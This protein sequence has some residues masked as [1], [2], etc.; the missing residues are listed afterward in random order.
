M[1]ALFDVGIP[2]IDGLRYQGEF[3]SREEELAL[4][5]AIRKLE[6]GAV[7]FRGVEARRRVVQFG[8]DYEFGSRKATPAEPVP[9]FLLALRKQ[10]GELIGLDPAR[11]EEV[12]VTEYQP[13]AGIGWHCDAPP[14]GVIV[15]V[16]LLSACTMRLRPRRGVAGSPVSID[17]APRSVYAFDGVVRSEWEHSIPPAKELRYSVTFRTMRRSASR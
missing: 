12:L 14:F 10:A 7:V 9:E 15:G 3:I 5:S 8:W 17:L 11:L 1:R 2:S 13:G 4:T 16:S 6:F